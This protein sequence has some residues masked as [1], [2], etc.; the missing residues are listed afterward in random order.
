MLGAILHHIRRHEGKILAITEEESN[1]GSGQGRFSH[2][3]LALASFSDDF[4]KT[5]QQRI[6]SQWLVPA[7]HADAG[8]R[9]K[10]ADKQSGSFAL[11]PSSRLT[12]NMDRSL[13][14]SW[15]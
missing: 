9:A 5:S 8:K 1:P 15:S 7:H 14:S 4:D 10:P 13:A 11:M 3:I 12:A 6:M 2:V